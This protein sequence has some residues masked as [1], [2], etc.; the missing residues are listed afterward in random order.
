MNNIHLLVENKIFFFFFCI[1]IIFLH[2]IGIIFPNLWGLHYFFFFSKITNYI[3]F[4]F[5]ILLLI[6]TL[7][8]NIEKI[9]IKNIN[10]KLILTFFCIIGFVIFYKFKSNINLLGDGRQL[11]DFI[12]NG[13]DKFY[14]KS[15]LEFYLHKGV[16]YLL[17]NLL[18]LDFNTTFSI[19]S[20]L[21]GS[22]YII[23]SYLISNTLTNDKYEQILIS[24]FLV[25]IGST[26][27]F[28][29]YI[30]LYSILS[31]LIMGFTYTFI[32][33]LKNELSIG[34][35]I[36]FAILCSLSHLLFSVIIF[37]ILITLY[38]HSKVSKRFIILAT[39]FLIFCFIALLYIVSYN[40]SDVFILRYDN[41]FSLNRLFDFITSQIN[42][43]PS[44]FCLLF[45]LLMIL[46]KKINFNS[47]IFIFLLSLSTTFLITLF[48]VK[49][50]LG[51]SR[52]WDILSISGFP[53]S[54]FVAYLIINYISNKEVVRYALIS[55]IIVN[56]FHTV[57]MVV[58]NHNETKGVQRF[59]L[60]LEDNSWKSWSKTAK[61]YGYADLA[62]Y[63]CQKKDFDNCLINLDKMV[64]SDKDSPKWR[65]F[66]DN[67]K[68]R[69]EKIKH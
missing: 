40:F 45:I 37:P 2:Y 10:S 14:W 69:I 59:N 51:Y 54:L 56:L 4:L 32:K 42:A 68:K 53:M 7:N 5:T 12:V 9:R 60:L 65:I 67:M 47:I 3:I 27:L 22:I 49:L 18:G 1:I 66:S 43:S 30:E 39:F 23:F 24:L 6:I 16:Y 21:A 44:G 17:N 11:F 36:I 63:Y 19:I 8:Y 38:F 15:P 62:M 48:S 20:C 64:E 25:T 33:Y 52:D 29:G 13:I 57:P 61:A 46:R 41:L 26:Q 35:P 34:I 55:I 58:V 28:Y 31:A 50:N